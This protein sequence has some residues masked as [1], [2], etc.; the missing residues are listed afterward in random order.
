MDIG[1]GY[2]GTKQQKMGHT[3]K[4]VMAHPFILTKIKVPRLHNWKFEGSVL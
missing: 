1:F 4:R 3:L 2:Y